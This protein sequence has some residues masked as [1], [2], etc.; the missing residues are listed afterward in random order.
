MGLSIWFKVGW[1]RLYMQNC[2]WLLGTA[3]LTGVAERTY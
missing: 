1:P 3:W 2:E